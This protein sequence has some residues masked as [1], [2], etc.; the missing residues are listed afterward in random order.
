MLNGT[1]NLSGQLNLASGSY[2]A[3]F[4]PVNFENNSINTG[5]ITC[6]QGSNFDVKESW[7]NNL[8]GLGK[9]QPINQMK[10]SEK[11]KLNKK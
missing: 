3:F 7:K 2:T 10:F 11:V 8:N 4:N 5:A 6:Q 1:I 9:A